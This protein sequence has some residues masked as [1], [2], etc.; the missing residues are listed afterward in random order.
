MSRASDMERRQ[1]APDRF[2]SSTP[3]D[4]VMLPVKWMNE[5]VSLCGPEQHEL[6]ER[7]TSSI[8]SARPLSDEQIDEAIQQ[9]VDPVATYRKL[10]DFARAIEDAHG[11]VR[12]ASSIGGEMTC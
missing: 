8:Q 10:H 5:L 2:G 4:C 3:S 1:R 7:V 12:A 6:R 9:H 11:I